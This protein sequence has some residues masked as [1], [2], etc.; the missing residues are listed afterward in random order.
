MN[1]EYI[2]NLLERYY[3]GTSSLADER[4]LAEYFA[5]ATDIPA[6]FEP[7]RKVFLMLAAGRRHTAGVDDAVLPDGFESRMEGVIDR[8]TRHRRALRL[9]LWSST[10]AA[11]LVLCAGI[12][13]H[14]HS[15]PAEV[16]GSSDLT[17]EEI[18]FYT[19]SSL[20]LLVSTL[21][22]GTAESAEAQKTFVKTTE[23]ALQQI[24]NL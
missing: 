1:N 19:E 23:T 3:A 10:V 24:E 2:K 20:S 11:M 17:E 8:M 21:E 16:S 15:R 12:M 7:D 13:W 14:Y 9:R 22:R 4:A 6:E 5:G 18:C